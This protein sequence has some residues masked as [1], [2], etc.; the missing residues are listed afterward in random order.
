MG[1]VLEQKI[2]RFDGGI[3]D[4]PRQPFNNVGAMVKHFDVFSNP[5]KLIPYRSTETE[6]TPIKT[7]DP[8]NFQLASNGLLYAL[9]KNASGYSKVVR[10]ADPTKGDWLASNGTAIATAVGEGTATRIPGCFIEWKSAFWFFEGNKIRKCTLTGVVSD[11]GT[12]STTPTTVAQGVVGRDN[13][14]Y[15]FY[16]NKVVR[17]SSASAETD[18]V[19]TLPDDMRITSACRYG[20]YIAIGLAY[21]TSATATPAGRSL[22][23]L[24][25]MS[26][27][28]VPS[29]VIAWGEGTLMCL[30]NVEERLVGV[31]NKYL[32]KTS[33]ES[34][35]IG[36]GSMVVRMWTGGVPQVVKEIVANQSVTQGRM[37]NEV[38][39]KGNKMYWVA[40]VPFNQST[41]TESTYHLGI[42]V[43][44]RKNVNSDFTISLDYID[45]NVSASNFYINS[46]GAAGNY[47][48]INHS[49]DFSVYKTNDAA[50]YSFSSTY[51]SQI[52]NNNDSAETKKLVG[53]TVYFAP[54]PTAGSVK[55]SYRKDEDTSYTT[56]YTH[57]TDD[58]LSHSAVNI[59]SSGATLPQYKE[60][61]FQIIS[62]GGAE[63]TGYK[64]KY[65]II[66][67]DI[68]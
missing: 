12:I 9:G 10:K 32:E 22:V 19:F 41:S 1:K 63:I 66:K 37:L 7:Y 34:L 48:F 29:D 62:T 4:D 67:S 5:Y 46:F 45:E 23:I 20:T 31:S 51:E 38:V 30:G 3:S 42:W 17:V 35:A 55:L 25:D 65:E 8:R 16:N 13:N 18:D 59:E 14:M 26:S 28:T 27:T 49:N 50:T 40:S 6:G 68:Y 56:I 39:I 44:G 60:I 53:V 15:M 57:T 47:W 52:L 64:F 36:G 54:L 43:F 33:L 58:S 24:W 2:N 61:Q 21:G 11:E